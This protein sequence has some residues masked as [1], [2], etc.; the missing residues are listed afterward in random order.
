MKKLLM[1]LPLALILCFMVGCQDKVAMAKLEAMKV[2][3]KV[4][5]QN[6]EVVRRYWNGKWNERR[7]EILDELMALNVGLVILGSGDES[8]Q[9]EI[10]KA[11]YRH[12][13]MIGIGTGFNNPLAHR[14]M[15][16]SDIFLVPSRYEPCGLTQMYALKYGTV[17]VVRATGGLND[18]IEAFDEKSGT[19]NGFKFGPYKADALLNEIK[20]AV[21]L[22]KVK[23]TWKKLVSP[24]LNVGTGKETAKLLASSLKAEPEVV[25]YMNEM[26][27]RNGVIK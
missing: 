1:I 11:V 6:K 24:I 25:A 13:G 17:P 22:Y 23:K 3:A 18:T 5:E 16:G 15:A 10:N 8:I 9:E 21:R 14:I 4:W 12:K 27:R 19:G 7:P 20:R 26:R 2:E